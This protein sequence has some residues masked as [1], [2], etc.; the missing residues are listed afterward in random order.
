[1]QKVTL[2]VHIICEIFTW[3]FI[4]MKTIMFSRNKIRTL[5]WLFLSFSAW[6]FL[7]QYVEADTFAERLY[8]IWL[9]I[10]TFSNKSSISRYEVT[11]LLNA[12]NCEDCVHAPDWMQ[13]KYNLD[14]R[15]L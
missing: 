7:L 11:R 9:D 5:L 8:D 2:L 13:E 6:L 4:R 10:N 3:F 15:N 14:Y 12:A 1:M